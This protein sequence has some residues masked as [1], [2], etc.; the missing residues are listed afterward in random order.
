MSAEKD[1]S[2]EKRTIFIPLL[3]EGTTVFRPTVGMH[4]RGNVFE[5]LPTDG[6]DPEDEEWEFP[7][8]TVVF[9]EKE[10]RDGEELYVARGR[11]ESTP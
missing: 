8:G 6:Y 11:A 4:L 7:P 5:V 9:C 10:V 1:S 3:N 2:T